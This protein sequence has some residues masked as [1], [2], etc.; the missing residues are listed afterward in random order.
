MPE[1]PIKYATHLA[2][3]MFP[4]YNDW[5]QQSVLFSGTIT[6]V[7]MEEAILDFFY[8]GVTV[9]I[10]DCGYEW[11]TDEPVVGRK[12]LYFCYMIC[13]TLAFNARFNKNDTIEAPEPN[14]RN[15]PEDLDTFQHFADDI[16]F[17]DMLS[18]WRDRY[19][20]VGTLLDHKIRDFCYVWIDVEYGEPG[21]WTE[22]TLEMNNEGKS[23]YEMAMAA[24][25]LP[26][27]NWSKRKNDMY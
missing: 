4:S 20:I 10:H 13:R 12:F 21:S 11:S 22:G 3:S 6:E 26:D 18:E 27:G 1:R 14:H 15:F 23:D 16:S 5:L 25:G 17:S 7:S 9:W 19:E 2:Y 24:G 8:R